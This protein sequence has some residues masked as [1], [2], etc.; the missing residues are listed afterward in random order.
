MTKF[1]LCIYRSNTRSVCVLGVFPPL[2]KAERELK[3]YLGGFFS[4]SVIGDCTFLP[5]EVAGDVTL[6][7]ITGLDKMVDW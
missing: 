2:S 7:P 4:L 6:D 5:A 1:R 3:L